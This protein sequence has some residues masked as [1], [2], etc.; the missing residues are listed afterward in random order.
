MVEAGQV[1]A[2]IDDSTGMVT[3]AEDPETHTS[4]ATAAALDA[5][6]RRAVQLSER[7]AALNEAVLL[8]P[9][10]LA[11]VAA[12]ERSA[13]GGHFGG[14]GGALGDELAAMPAFS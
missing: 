5:A 12:R 10:Y 2:R 11:K 3:F 8:E 14:G 9:A 7:V 6:I 1:H 13:G 4:S